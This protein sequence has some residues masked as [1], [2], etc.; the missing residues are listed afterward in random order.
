MNTEVLSFYRFHHQED[1]EAAA[2]AFH[3]PAEAH[4][5]LG[6]VL[7]ASEGWNV[8]L[9]GTTDRLAAYLRA[10]TKS[11]EFHPEAAEIKRMRVE[12]APFRKLVQRVKPEIIKFGVPVDV[13]DGQGT[14]VT[15]QQMHSMLKDHSD[16]ILMLDVRNNYEKHA[17]TFKDAVDYNIESFCDL[18]EAA[19]QRPLPED[20]TVITFCTGGIRCEK[21]VPYLRSLGY[22]NVLQIEGGIWRY[23]EQYPNGFFQG[24]CFWF[25]EREDV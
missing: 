1:P 22:N 8:T 18:P 23:L 13:R 9:C 12:T 19:Q 3:E 2:R 24:K 7:T 17:G 6:T 10:L 11:K 15:P 16:E 4:G 20:K 5:L 21:A 14:Y 25:D